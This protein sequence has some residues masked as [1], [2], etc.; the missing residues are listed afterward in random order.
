MKPHGVVEAG[1]LYF[2]ISPADAVRQ[3][4][5]VNKCHIARVGHN[6]GMQHTVGRQFAICAHPHPLTQAGVSFSGK[7]III[8]VTNID[9]SRSVVP[10]TELLF[11]WLH[12]GFEVRKI[13]WLGHICGH[14]ELEVKTG[15]GG[16][17]AGL[18]VEDCFSIL[19][20]NNSAG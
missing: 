4:R 17:E 12:A 15:F 18:H 2:A 5:S 9:W 19:N 11:V 7:W 3:Q 20:C 16:V 14:L 10:L 6:A 8:D 1:H 13:F